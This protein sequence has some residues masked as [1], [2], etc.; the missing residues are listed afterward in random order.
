M[1]TPPLLLGAG[2]LFWG[3][4]A[5][6]LVEGALMAGLLEGAQSVKARWDFTDEDF[7]RIWTF[8]ALLLFGAALYA[9]TSTGGP[10]D[11]RGFFQDPNLATERNMGNASARTVAALMRWLPMIFFLFMAAQAFSSREGV[12]PETISVIMRLRW[13]KARK[14]GQTVP[15][16]RSVDISYPYFV[17]C[18]FAASFHPRED[19]G[20]YWGLCALLT[21]A[22]W[23]HRSRRFGVVVWAGALGTAVLLGYNGQRGVGRI[24]RSLENLNAQWFVRPIGGGTDP[25]T[26]KTALGQIGWLNGSSKIVIRLEPRDGSRAPT[27]L[28]EASYR[29]W[30]GQVWYS[31]LARDSFESVFESADHTTWV[32]LPGKTNSA[33]VNIACYLPRRSGLLPLP[34]GTGRLENLPAWVVQKSSLGAVLVEGPGLVIFD[35]RYEPGTTIDS[36]AVTNVDTHVPVKEIPALDQVIEELH[37]KQQS[38][39]QVLRTLSAYFQDESKFRYCTWQNLERGRNTNATPVAR[40]LRSTRRG[41]CE[42]FATAT[43]LLLRQLGIPARYAVGYAV[44]E[45]SGKQYIVRQR[46]AHAWCLVWNPATETWQDFDTTPSSWVAAEARRASPLQRLSDSWSWIVF[47]FARFRWGQSHLRQ[48]LLWG[49]VPV[50]AL[51]LYQ[52]I[53]RSRRQRQA[54][55]LDQTGAKLAWPGLDS[56]FYQV[57]RKLLERAP[58]RQP[59]EPLSVWLL[60]TSTDPALAN[61]KNRLREL[62]SLHYRYRFDPEG[63]TQTDR[64]ALRREASG[65]LARLV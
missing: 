9:F 42:Y 43:V 32:L 14:L 65:C 1:K 26:S 25:R 3:W 13:Q 58:P 41:H 55:N 64:E 30:K 60:R 61:V 57:E 5:G 15:G 2:L 16:A 18:L 33:A 52:I 63:L 39:R 20:F 21:W 27:L 10:G 50:L 23:P 31:E 46:D 12:P 8:C 22:L 44:H 47:E 56:E 45:T 6:H 17:L 40:F 38:R 19:Q 51:L 37:L 54:A 24:Y 36:P 62:L 49:L 11:F 29:T 28:R 59:F 7:R 35:A 48:Y 4:Q 34:T 53:F